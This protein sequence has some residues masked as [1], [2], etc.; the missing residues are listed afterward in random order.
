MTHVSRHIVTRVSVGTDP[1]GTPL[2]LWPGVT[3]AGLMA[4]LRWGVPAV[5]PEAAMFA[6]LSGLA[7]AAAILVW[8]LFFSRAA[9]VERLGATALMAVALVATRPVL[10][11]SIQNGMMGMMFFIYVIPIL[12]LAFVIWA[13]A[14]RRLG[15]GARRATLVAAI[16][17]ACG[18]LALV[19]TD[20]LIGGGGSQFAW[21]W[22]PTAEERLLARADDE[23]TPLATSPSPVD[24]LTQAASTAS[25]DADDADPQ[26][27]V[28]HPSAPGEG[29]AGPLTAADPAMARDTRR[30]DESGPS[31]PGVPPVERPAARAPRATRV[32]WPG[33]RGLGRDAVVRG[34]RVDTDWSTRPPV[35]LWRRAIGPGWSSFAIAD[36][37]FYTQEQRGEDELVSAYAL[38]TGAPVWR[39]R[40][41]A[42]FWES[43][44]GAGPRGT[45]T[46]DNGRVYA[47]GATGILNVLDA[48]TGAV[49]W[50]RDAASDTGVATPG[51]GFSG[52][53]LVIDD[54]VI[55]ATS[56]VLAAY[57]TATGDPRWVSR[58]PGGG[59]YSSPHLATIDGV[60]Q[61]LLMAGGGLRSVAPA[62]GSLLWEHAWPG[63]PIVQPALLGDG[64][65]VVS[66]SGNTGALGLRRLAVAR[67]AGGWSVDPRWTSNGLKPYF[68]DFVV[69]EGHAY[70]FDG[71]IL[72][73]LD[74]TDG[75]RKWKGGRYG[76]GQ[77][78]LLPDQDLLLVLSEEGEIALV[79]ATPDKF[80]ELARFA[81]IQGKTWNH[82]AMAGD[83]LLV[84]NGEEMAAFRLP[85]AGR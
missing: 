38:A 71:F 44:G 53:P 54:T 36:G 2:R 34:L 9:W 29:I 8:W 69:H 80:A 63:A 79:S 65:L 39:H 16:A 46:L 58:V 18:S 17:L 33:F 25:G 3:A 11:E 12:S 27:P 43:N 20:G 49:V 14:S 55:V 75:T 52:S 50:S 48:R 64:H 57:D 23:P 81:A 67:G 56:G 15:R 1:S 42:R 28:S 84:R 10:H 35:E 59:S 68:N 45:P 74:L 85:L 22:T 6:V 26:P 4:L 5:V 24:E 51:W 40:D 66:T 37:V 77:M 83:V 78:V 30:A 61:V 73:S 62:D 60:P 31:E 70:G 7:A 13:V 32:E 76:H 82:P 41:A 72:A 47:L 21:R 19:R